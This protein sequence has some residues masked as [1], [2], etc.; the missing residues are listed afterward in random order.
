[1]KAFPTLLAVTCFLVSGILQIVASVNI[2]ESTYYGFSRLCW[3]IVKPGI[4]RLAE[5]L[6][7]T[8]RFQKVQMKIKLMKHCDKAATRWST[9]ITR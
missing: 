6:L 8:L 9:P 4:A 3:H 7:E 5:K 2:P 1:M